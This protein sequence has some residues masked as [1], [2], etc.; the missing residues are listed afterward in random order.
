MNRKSVFLILLFL[1]F[2]ICSLYA[3]LQGQARID[4]L[5]NELPKQ[6][7]DTNMVKLLATISNSYMKVSPDEGIKYAQQALELA[8][9]LKWKKGIGYANSVMGANYE[10]KSNYPMALAYDVKALQLYKE[11]GYKNG[12]AL[13]LMDIG[14]VYV[15]QDDHRKAIEYYN[16]AIETYRELGDKEGIARVTGNIGTFYR[17]QGDYTNALACY[18]KALKLHEENGNNSAAATATGNIGN[19]YS[20]LNDEARSMEFYQK[21]LKMFEELGDKSGITRITGSIGSHYRS[22]K[23]YAKALEFEFK[24]LKLAEEI[25][26][27]NYEA[28]NIT[29]IGNVY[30]NQKN[31]T[32][33]ITYM[34]KALKLNEEMGDKG[35]VALSLHNLGALYFSIAEQGPF[36]LAKVAQ[37]SEFPVGRYRP[38]A[39]IPT[40]KAGQLQKA[41]EYLNKALVLSKEI[42]DLRVMQGTYEVLADVYKLKGDY[43][44]ALENSDRAR[45]ISD[46]VFSS[47]NKEQVLKLGMKN[48]YD[49]QHLAD[50]LKTAEKE[51][52]AAINLQKQKMYTYMGI[53]GILLLAGFSFFIV[54]ERGKSEKERKKSDVLLLNILP[55]EV[56]AELKS[57]GT[58][59][60]RQFDNVTVLFTDFV[61]FTEAAEIMS[62]QNLI[63]ELHTCFMAFDEITTRFDIEKVKTIGDAY[64]AIAGLPTADP[65]HAENTV[66]AAL[67]INKFMADRLAKLGADR[68]FRIRIGIHSGSVVAGIVGVKK[69]AYDIWGDTV[70]TAARMEQNSEAGKINI[71]ETTHELVKA[72]F[73]CEYRGEVAVKGKGAMKMYYVG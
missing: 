31:Y 60:A 36:A 26:N 47:N 44:Q 24:A 69:F 29:S 50:S 30:M 2:N 63:D 25:G 54:K 72:K 33:G 49:R 48:E 10:H 71:S 16:K 39:D 46:S 41:V 40:S 14:S 6:K 4:S 15:S 34:L 62:P 19:V 18:F 7:E 65:R 28:I 56:A 35:G 61:N 53:A 55:E 68:T 1:C 43:K 57:T 59:T 70:N 20:N 21:A 45:Q 9:K 17:R 12:V 42:K 64:L 3:R 13:V 38:T 66:K 8:T 23:N 51:K 22:Q 11:I 37:S 73:A 27:K 58:T 52:I 5:L 67:E 32:M